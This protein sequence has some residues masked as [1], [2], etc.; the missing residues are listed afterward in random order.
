MIAVPGGQNAG[1]LSNVCPASKAITTS[2]TAATRIPSFHPKSK[3]FQTLR[4]HSLGGKAA[5]MEI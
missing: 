5:S 4:S 1:E 2:T 3:C